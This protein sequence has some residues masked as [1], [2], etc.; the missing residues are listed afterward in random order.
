MAGKL[1]ETLEETQRRLALGSVTTA[2]MM[3]TLDNRHRARGV[4]NARRGPRAGRLLAVIGVVLGI[5]FVVLLGLFLVGVLGD[6]GS[7]EVAAFVTAH[8]R[9]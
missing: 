4:S 2:P 8:A 5:V 9:L 6:G 7:G 1:L 3:Q